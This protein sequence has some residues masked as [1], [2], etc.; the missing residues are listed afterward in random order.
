MGRDRA[1]RIANRLMVGGLLVGA[2]AVTVS[3][4]T[5]RQGVNFHVSSRT[6]PLHVKLVDFLD[7][8]WH[9]NLLA[10]EI[11][12]GC[13]TDEARALAVFAWTREHIKPTPTGWPIVDD[14]ILNIIIRGYGVSD[15]MADVFATLAMYAGVDAFWKAYR[16]KGG[17]PEAIFSFA[18]MNG[19]WAVFDVGRGVIFRNPE[20]QLASVEQLVAHPDWAAMAGEPLQPSGFSYELFL[21]QLVPFEVPRP[22]RATLQM[23]GPRCWYET[24]KMLGL[25][26]N[27]ETLKES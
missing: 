20:G 9:Y 27:R 5:T 11:T 22:L 4:A 21:P 23:P 14:H 25:E 1:R 12:Q 13:R 2:L 16:L 10:K 19:K 7:R 8:H 26:R 15:Q 6:V 24:R 18:R 3:P 17:T